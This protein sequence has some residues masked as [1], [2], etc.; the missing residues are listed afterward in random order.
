MDVR[1]QLLP[2]LVLTVVLL[3]CGGSTVE[4]PRAPAPRS[5]VLAVRTSHDSALRLVRYSFGTIEGQIQV[6]QKRPHMTMLSTHYVRNRDGG[7]EREVAIMAAVD[8][9]GADSVETVMELAAWIL[10]TPQRQTAAQRRAGMP[11]TPISTNAPARMQPRVVTP[12]DSVDWRLFALVLA[13]LRKQ[14]ARQLP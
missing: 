10:D 5:F 4:S 9:N 12:A 2:E 13:E 11:A 1:S 14:G 7:G 8:R 3:A 6:P